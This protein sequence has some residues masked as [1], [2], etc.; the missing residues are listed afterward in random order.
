MLRIMM[1]SDLIGEQV[2]ARLWQIYG[3]YFSQIELTRWNKNVGS[4]KNLP[5]SQRRGAIMILGMLAVADKGIVENQID[6][7][8]KVGFGKQGT[9]SPLSLSCSLKTVDIVS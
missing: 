5:S 4:N 7:M 8:L 9:V 1:E 3:Q 2:I 6:T